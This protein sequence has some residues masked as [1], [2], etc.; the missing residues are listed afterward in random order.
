MQEK[1]E[2]SRKFRIQNTKEIKSENSQAKFKVG[3]MFDADCRLP[4]GRGNGLVLD[5]FIAIRRESLRCWLIQLALL[6]VIL[7]QLTFF[8]VILVQLQ[9]WRRVVKFELK[10][11]RWRRQQRYLRPRLERP[12]HALRLPHI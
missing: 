3:N 1:H 10:L 2:V 4:H 12:R 11:R 5:L 8:L 9:R 7:V 6:L